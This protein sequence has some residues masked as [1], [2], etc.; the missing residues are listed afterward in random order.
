MMILLLL[1]RLLGRWLIAAGAAVAMLTLG[2][3]FIAGARIPW[4]VYAI[5][6]LPLASALLVLHPATQRWCLPG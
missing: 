4:P 6:A 5:P 3:V 2:S 1:H